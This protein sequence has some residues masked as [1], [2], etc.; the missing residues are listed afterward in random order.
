MNQFFFAE[1]GSFFLWPA[2]FQHFTQKKKL[3]KEETVAALGTS[4]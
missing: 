4:F 1:S 2:I 3:K